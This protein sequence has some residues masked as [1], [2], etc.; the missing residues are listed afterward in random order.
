MTSPY[1]TTLLTSTINLHPKQMNNQIYKNLKENLTQKLEKKC[2]KNYGYI[3]KVIELVE[4]SDGVLVPENPTS[5]A[6]FSV[7]FSCVLC[8]PLKKSQIVAKIE[9]MNNTLINLRNGPITIIVTMDR[10]NRDIFYQENR[11]NKLIAKKGDDKEEVTSGKYMVVSIEKKLFSDMDQ[12]ITVIG[13]LVRPA[14]NDEISKSFRDEYGDEIITPFSEYI[15]LEK[16]AEQ[17]KPAD[18][19]NQVE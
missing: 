12:I 19:E 4:Y 16:K 18:I 5:S 11:T 1:I 14:T 3:S 7:K 8:N 9:K 15:E 6:T 13:E 2:F 10:I 17:Q